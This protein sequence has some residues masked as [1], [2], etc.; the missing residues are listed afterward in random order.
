MNVD[1]RAIML[2]IYNTINDNLTDLV[3]H[4]LVSRGIL[5]E[6][7]VKHSKEA[8]E[9]SFDGY[10]FITQS[11]YTELK[12]YLSDKNVEPTSLLLDI[13]NKR[14]NVQNLFAMNWLQQIHFFKHFFNQRITFVTGGTGTGKST[15][16]P[17]LLWYGLFFL[18]E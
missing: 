12:S 8:I 5:N 10:Y 2:K 7:K 16:V 14:S 17:K 18:L 15:Q 1:S 13:R 4:C 9:E 6:F 11:K 3:F